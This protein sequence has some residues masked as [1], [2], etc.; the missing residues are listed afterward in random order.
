MILS[1][2]LGRSRFGG[3][4]SKC[5]GRLGGN[6]PSWRSRIAF[7]RIA[8]RGRCN[9][10]AICFAELVGHRATSSRSSSS[11]QRMAGLVDHGGPSAWC[12]AFRSRRYFGE[13]RPFPQTLHLAR[14]GVDFG[15]LANKQQSDQPRRLDHWQPAFRTRPRCRRRLRCH[16][17]RD[18][19]SSASFGLVRAANSK[20]CAA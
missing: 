15:S 6:S 4:T 7:L 8:E 5:L 17:L 11:V 9:R 13:P 14:V 12:H 3:L 20:T 1:F 19:K 18:R 16:V 10:L 2:G